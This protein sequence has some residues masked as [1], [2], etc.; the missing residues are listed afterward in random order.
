[1]RTWPVYFVEEREMRRCAGARYQDRRIETA[2]IADGA[3]T[4]RFAIADISFF[5]PRH[6]SRR[7]RELNGSISRIARSCLKAPHMH[8]ASVNMNSFHLTPA[9]FH[10]SLDG[11]PCFSRLRLEDS[12]AAESAYSCTR[13]S[14]RARTHV[15]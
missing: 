6:N 5:I 2:S 1:M 13:V 9:E 12:A 8:A 3:E 15:L 7:N 10:V 14:A 11:T 4:R